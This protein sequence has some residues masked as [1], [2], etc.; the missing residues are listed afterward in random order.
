VA[1]TPDARA[2][3]SPVPSGSTPTTVAT[4]P[5]PP[6]GGTTVPTSTLTSPFPPV[7]APNPLP[8]LP[9]DYIVQEEDWLSKLSLKFY[10]D[11]RAYPL[12]VEATNAKALT[13]DSYAFIED[14]DLIEIGWK[15]HIPAV[16]E[17][18]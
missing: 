7:F 2:T 8:S 14:P 10:G 15:I 5:A 4:S 1:N 9:D 12:I 18:P 3:G 17:I 11:I 16:S 6:L 13:D